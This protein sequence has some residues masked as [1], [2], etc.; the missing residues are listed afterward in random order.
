MTKKIQT[1]LELLDKTE[2]IN[3][4]TFV[5]YVDNTI[6]A[7]PPLLKAFAEDIHCLQ[8]LGVT[9]IIIHDGDKSLDN[10][11]KELN[12]DCH[13][14]DNIQISEMLLTGFVNKNIVSEINKMGSLAANISGKDA[15]LIEALKIRKVQSNHNSNVQHI[16]HD[17]DQGI[18]ES[19]NPDILIALENSNIIPVISPLA[20]VKGRT[21]Q[22]EGLHTAALICSFLAADRF[23]IMSYNQD[24]DQLSNINNLSYEELLL[25][26]TKKNTPLHSLVEKCKIVFE[27]NT[28]EVIII[29]NQKPHALLHSIID[30]N[31]DNVIINNDNQGDEYA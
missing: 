11:Y 16:I 20:E 29:K 25:T 26:K 13:L 7:S 9:I 31:N 10:A 18:A 24:Y 23:I 6:I 21:V 4:E 17:Y 19:I 27:S 30:E 3:N 14:P 5:I 8:R 28:Q 1:L 15:N 22:L 12:I 2:S